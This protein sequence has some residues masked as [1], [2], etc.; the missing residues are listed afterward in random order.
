MLYTVLIAS[1]ASGC[2]HARLKLLLVLFIDII[3]TLAVHHTCRIIRI[4]L[5]ALRSNFIPLVSSTSS[6]LSSRTFVSSSPRIRVCLLHTSNIYLIL[7]YSFLFCSPH[8]RTCR[9]AFSQCH[10][11][12]QHL[13][14]TPPA[15]ERE[16][17]DT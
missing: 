7:S 1:L 8:T 2:H 12:M 15:H 4:I 14:Y 11:F 16:D 17:Y 13:H 9:L 5:F 3:I 6:T 10:C